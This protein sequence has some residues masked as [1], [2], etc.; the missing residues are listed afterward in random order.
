MAAPRETRPGGSA[1]CGPRR[2]RVQARIDRTHTRIEVLVENDNEVREA[3]ARTR[4]EQARTRRRS[5]TPAAA[6]AAKRGRAGGRLRQEAARPAARVGRVRPS[7]Y[8]RSGLIWPPT[9]APGSGCR[10]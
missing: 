2:A 8:D 5:L 7:S 1:A 9:A 10:G 4:A 6:W 3:L